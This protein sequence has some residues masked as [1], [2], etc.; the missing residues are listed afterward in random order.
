MIFI[1][2]F[3]LIALSRSYTTV[4]AEEFEV[5]NVIYPS[6]TSFRALKDV[7][8]S[9]RLEP[10]CIWTFLVFYNT[11]IIHLSNHTKIEDTSFHQELYSTNQ[12]CWVNHFKS[13]IWCQVFV[14]PTLNLL[15]PPHWPSLGA[16]VTGG[17][18]LFTLQRQ[19]TEAWYL[20]AQ[21]MKWLSISEYVCY[22]CYWIA[23]LWKMSLF[24][25][26]FHW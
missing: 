17:S 25:G 22:S 3:I 4:K 7:L 24:S 16:P 6:P 12:C 1:H 23:V 18:S 21:V 14:H 10:T 13:T 9:Q 20:E 26:L 5:E 15:C 8:P 2:V 11:Y 19:S